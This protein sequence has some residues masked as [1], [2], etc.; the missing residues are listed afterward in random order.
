[1]AVEHAVPIRP[2]I[3]HGCPSGAKNLGVAHPVDAAKLKGRIGN[4]LPKVFDDAPASFAFN[5]QDVLIDRKR[6]LRTENLQERFSKRQARRRVPCD[7]CA[8]LGPP[9]QAACAANDV[10]EA[11]GRTETF[12]LEKILPVPEKIERRL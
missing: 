4:Q 3:A 12:G 5:L 8:L 7:A 11:N 1:M 6:A 10:L 9:L 2:V